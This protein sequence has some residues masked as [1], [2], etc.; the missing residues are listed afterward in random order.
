MATQPLHPAHQP[1]TFPG[2]FPP[3]PAVARILSRFDHDQLAGFIAVAIDLADALDG[4]ADPD[5]A[6]F[7]P[8]GDRLDS[9]LSPACRPDVENRF[10]GPAQ[11]RYAAIDGARPASRTGDSAPPAP[12]PRGPERTGWRRSSLTNQSSSVLSWRS[13]ALAPIGEPT[14]CSS[15]DPMNQFPRFFAT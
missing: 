9:T 6:D 11:W 2:A 4:P 12:H 10:R 1:V 14:L 8:L 7:S 5:S 15:F 13:W 3:M